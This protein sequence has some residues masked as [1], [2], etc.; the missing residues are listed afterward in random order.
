LKLY[1]SDEKYYEFEENVFKVFIDKIK[2]DEKKI[3]N[4]KRS[5]KFKL[6]NYYDFVKKRTF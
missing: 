6:I 5:D 4:I 1:D 2:K 3:K